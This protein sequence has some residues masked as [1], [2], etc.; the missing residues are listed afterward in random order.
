MPQQ[1]KSEIKKRRG[2]FI[3]DG[4]PLSEELVSQ[5]Y[6]SF[7]AENVYRREL[8]GVKGLP[9]WDEVLRDIA[10]ACQLHLFL[11]KLCK[12]GSGD[13]PSNQGDL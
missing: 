12:G 1:K 13:A 2:Y 11:S 9:G 8:C 10:F 5:S 7:Y 6:V 4:T 3:V